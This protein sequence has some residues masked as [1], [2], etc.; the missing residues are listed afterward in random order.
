[1]AYRVGPTASLSS[2]GSFGQ[3]TSASGHGG[4]RGRVTRHRVFFTLRTVLPLY[5]CTEVLSLPAQWATASVLVPKIWGIIW[6]PF[7]GAWS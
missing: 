7:V 1:M 3:V 4:L 2:N 6:D 5:F